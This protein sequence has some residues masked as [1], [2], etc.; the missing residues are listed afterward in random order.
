MIDFRDASS[1]FVSSHGG[2]LLLETTIGPSNA[3]DSFNHR[4]PWSH[5]QSLIAVIPYKRKRHIL[6]SQHCNSDGT[7]Y[8]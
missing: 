6:C 5:S 3:G 4:T 7:H 8:V 2:T 1:K